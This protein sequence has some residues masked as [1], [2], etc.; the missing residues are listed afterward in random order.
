MKFDT[1]LHECRIISSSMFLPAENALFGEQKLPPFSFPPIDMFFCLR[2]QAAPWLSVNKIYT[3]G[4]RVY[5]P[6]TCHLTFLSVLAI[7][8]LCWYPVPG[9]N[10]CIVGVYESTVMSLHYDMES[11]SDSLGPNFGTSSWANVLLVEIGIHI[12]FSWLLDR[13]IW[14]QMCKLGLC[15]EP[16]DHKGPQNLLNSLTFCFYLYQNFETIRYKKYEFNPKNYY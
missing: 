9:L 11:I 3:T 12:W 5:R 10:I 6:T 7:R 16:L 2:M 1:F 8:S 13:L 14:Y 15:K 4:L